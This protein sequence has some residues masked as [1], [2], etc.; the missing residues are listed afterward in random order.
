MN[1]YITLLILGVV[2]AAMLLVLSMHAGRA[3]H[4][5]SDTPPAVIDSEDAPTSPEAATPDGQGATS[6]APESG[7]AP[8][9]PGQ[10]SGGPIRLDAPESSPAENS[11]ARSSQALQAEKETAASAQPPAPTREEQRPPVVQTQRPADRQAEPRPAAQI[12]QTASASRG[13]GVMRNIGLSFRGQSMALTLEA[14][15]SLPAKYFILTSPERLVVD[16]PGAWKN[17]KAPAVPRNNIVKNIRLGRQGDADRLVLDLSRKLKS[18]S[19]N[20]LSDN[21]VELVFQ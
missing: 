5:E 14:D 21:K 13:Q 2:G 12:P 16:L 4:E 1:K 7:A 18:H 10:E 11:P 3:P 8:S 20:R 6:P 17:I 15:S 9:A 19:L